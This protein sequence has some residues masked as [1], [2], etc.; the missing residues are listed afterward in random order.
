MRESLS[1]RHKNGAV[2]LLFLHIVF[3]MDTSVEWMHLP[4]RSWRR[5]ELICSSIQVM[6]IRELPA[7]D[8]VFTPSPVNQIRK[9]P[10]PNNF[11]SVRL[12]T[13][14]ERRLTLESSLLAPDTPPQSPG[15]IEFGNFR[16]PARLRDR[17]S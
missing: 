13:K 14:F 2:I 15:S 5:D 16:T 11:I 17:L 6:N 9:A 7:V 4:L 8:E 10:S 3:L 12:N 1:L